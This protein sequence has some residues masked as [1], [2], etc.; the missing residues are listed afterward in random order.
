MAFYSLMRDIGFKELLLSIVVGLAI[1]ITS[2]Y[3]HI[4]PSLN[5]MINFKTATI[6]L[7]EDHFSDVYMQQVVDYHKEH[8][9]FARRVLSTYLIK[10]TQEKF[11]LSIAQSFSV[12]NFLLIFLSG[13]LVFYMAKIIGMN[14]HSALLSQLI[15]HLCFS[16]F[17]AF[18]RTNYTYDEPMQYF[19][20]LLALTFII[21][22]RFFMLVVSLFFALLA[23]ESSIVV[24]PSMFFLYY[25]LYQEKLRF[26]FQFIK[27]GLL[28]TIPVV[29]Y[30]IFYIYHLSTFEAGVEEN[31]DEL[32]VRFSQLMYNFQNV[33]FS[34]ESIALFIIISG[35]PVVLLL[36][37]SKE[38]LNDEKYKFRLAFWVALVLNTIMVYV[39]ARVNES[40]VL[41]LPLIFLWPLVGNY[42]LNCWN[43][44]KHRTTKKV[45]IYLI[46]VM[47]FMA[48]VSYYIAIRIYQPTGAAPTENWFNEYFFIL[49]LLMSFIVSF[50]FLTKY[51]KVTKTF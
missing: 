42:A 26:D 20:C 29:M 50:C 12:I 33:Q 15:Y 13:L 45:L 48:L 17:F 49:L 25:F 5:S 11:G 9:V 7:E 41:A 2:F 24:F 44:I 37:Q 39:S 19:F 8:P 3:I 16:V 18:F 6:N 14:Q 23:R 40:R 10:T 28:F 30:L 34:I 36:A 43:Q 47:V 38:V 32:N 51:L 46:P 35:L 27:K 22:E 4:H 1:T 21:K 31:Y